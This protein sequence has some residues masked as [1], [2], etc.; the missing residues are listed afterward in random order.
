MNTLNIGNYNKLKVVKTV[1]FGLYLEGDKG[2][3][4][5]LPTRYV[6]KNAAIGDEIDVFIY[7]DNEERLIATTEK[8]RGTVGEFC[9]MRVKDKSAAGAFL[10]WGIMKDL[11]VPF[12]EQKEEMRAGESYLVYIY[13]DFVTK[14]IVASSRLDKFLDNVPP[15]YVP[16]QEVELIVANKTA[17]GYNVIINNL[18]WGL[19]YNNEIFRQIRTGEKCR[20]YI[21]RIREDDKIDV[22]IYPLGYDKTETVTDSILNALKEN[23]G[24][25]PVNDKTDA[26]Q[27]YSTFACSKKSFKQAIGSLYKKRLITIE[28]KGIFLN[29]HNERQ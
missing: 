27:I 11:L 28:D 23:N 13:L 3:E 18:H 20:G 2:Q 25:L 9:Y 29:F 14:R 22:S 1:D 16:N 15:E 10:D 8:P 26:E 17:L 12:R 4:I 6:P 24:F 19:I 7:K 21:K 5:L